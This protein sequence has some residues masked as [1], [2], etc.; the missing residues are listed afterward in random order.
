M[1]ARYN[2]AR[3]R[4]A[5]ANPP[6][7]FEPVFYEPDSELDER[8]D[9]SPTTQFFKDSS[10]SFITYNRS[11]DVDFEASINPYRGCEHGCIYCYARPTHEYFGF[12]AGLDFEA[13]ILVKEDGPEL[14]ARELS[15]PNWQPQVVGVS[16]VTD[17]YQP[18]ERRLQ[19]TRR[20][21][22]VFVR[23]KNPVAI[24]TKNYLVTRDIDLLARLAEINAVTVYIS[25]TTMDAHLGRVMEPRTSVPERRLEA[26]NRLSRKGIETGVLVA[27]VIPGMTEHEIPEI[28]KAA[29]EAGAKCAGYIMLRLPHGVAPLFEGWLERNYPDRKEKVLNRIR[30][31]RGGKLNDPQYGSRMRGDGIFADQIENLFSLAC[32]RVGLETQGPELNV[33]GFCG[34]A[35]SQLGLF[36]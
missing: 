27:P 5:A 6:N 2:N 23:F 18:V 31:I 21:L 30:S 24:I 10:K 16:G 13:K 17:P 22:E 32:K 19:L 15:H 25:I 26:I 35:D 7:R 12:S 28:L 34:P 4:G 9:V 3:G 33:S 14:L 11:P 36:N 29:S 1:P 20:C 8:A